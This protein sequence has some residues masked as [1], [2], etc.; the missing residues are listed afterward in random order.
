MSLCTWL[1]LHD[2]MPVY[3]CLYWGMP[4]YDWFCDWLYVTY[5]SLMLW[6]GHSHRHRQAI[7]G[8]KSDYHNQSQQGTPRYSQANKQAKAMYLRPCPR[9]VTL[10]I[11][12]QTCSQANTDNKTHQYLPSFMRC[13]VYLY[14]YVWAQKYLIVEHNQ[15]KPGY[16]RHKDRLT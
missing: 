14:V 4:R 13:C 16:H 9:L 1:F 5:T 7:T 8:T 10:F 11:I 12:S 2:F 15:A 3:T 6:P